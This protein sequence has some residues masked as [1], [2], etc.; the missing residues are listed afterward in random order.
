LDL[1]YLILLLQVDWCWLH[2]ER[3]SGL[4]WWNHS[5]LLMGVSIMWIVVVGWVHFG[6][7]VAVTALVHREMWPGRAAAL[8]HCCTAA[9]SARLTSLLF[10]A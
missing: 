3:C 5:K 4:V 2:G 1:T 7:F 9:H 6:D 10:A 8:Y